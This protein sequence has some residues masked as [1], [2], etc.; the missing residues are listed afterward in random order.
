MENNTTNNLPPSAVG[1]ETGKE[2]GAQQADDKVLDFLAA[3]H[4]DDEGALEAMT[5]LMAEGGEKLLE[6]LYKGLN[7]DKSSQEAYVRGRNE[8]I[9]CRR[10]EQ[11]LPD[12]APDAKEGNGTHE[13]LSHIRPSV[14]DDAERGNSGDVRHPNLSRMVW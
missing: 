7:A 6:T 5:Q 14:W 8:N 2:S 13:V 12:G 11:M 9:E 3:K 10:R 1:A 4:P